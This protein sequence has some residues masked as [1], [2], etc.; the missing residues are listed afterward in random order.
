MA[1]SGVTRVSAALTVPLIECH[2][3]A[4]DVGQRDGTVDV[5]HFD[6]AL[7]RV[8]HHV[9]TVDR[10]QPEIGPRRHLNVEID[11]A[12]ERR[13]D[14]E[15]VVFFFEAEASR[16]RQPPEAGWRVALRQPR[17]CGPGPRL[18]HDVLA[19]GAFHRDTARHHV[20]SHGA[21]FRRIAEIDGDALGILLRR[22]LC[23]DRRT[24]GRGDQPG[25]R[26]SHRVH[27]GFLSIWWR[28]ARARR[29]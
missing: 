19:I 3:R 2:D 7:H 26:D 4:R 10:R 12:S 16:R 21:R 20:D 17:R 8:D 11:A 14:R 13:A 9:A 24:G 28:A 27:S 15:L 29:H 5:V 18:D 25:K 22:H 6:L 1:L 23:A